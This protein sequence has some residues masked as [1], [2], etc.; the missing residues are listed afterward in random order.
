MDAEF[1]AKQPQAVDLEALSDGQ[2]MPA[3]PSGI[4]QEPQP[5]IPSADDISQE[6]MDWEPDYNE[7]DIP[8]P[9]SPPRARSPTPPPPAHLEAPDDRQEVAIAQAKDPSQVPDEITEQF[10][11]PAGTVLAKDQSHFAI[12]FQEHMRMH[13]ENI[14][15]PFANSIDWDLAAW[16]HESGMSMAEMDRFLATQYVS[17]FQF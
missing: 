12:I 8:G 15:Y 3:G 9:Q 13:D 17:A 5:A 1:L 10:P 4:P 2:A 16:M 14:Y 7:I 6:P 11:R